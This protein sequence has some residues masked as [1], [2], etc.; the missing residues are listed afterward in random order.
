[1]DLK[2]E[3]SK[4]GTRIDVTKQIGELIDERV[5]KESVEQIKQS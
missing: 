5:R 4:C 3:C 2:I 1:M